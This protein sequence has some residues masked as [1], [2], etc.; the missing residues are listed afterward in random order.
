MLFLSYPEVRI[1]GQPEYTFIANAPTHQAVRRDRTG[2][3]LTARHD[4]GGPRLSAT[5]LNAPPRK[6][7]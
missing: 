5:G 6:R 1:P 4:A 7:R 3:V 2:R